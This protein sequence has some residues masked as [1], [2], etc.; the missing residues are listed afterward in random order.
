MKITE[1]A[2]LLPLN[3]FHIDVKAKVLAE[4]DTEEELIALLHRYEGERL[5][6]IGEGSN[7]LF[8]QDFDGVV[9][10]SRMRRASALK[11]NKDEVW[12]EAQSGLLLDNLISQLADM[13]LR[14]M[15]N[16]SYIPGTVGASAV[17]NVGAY[18]VE[19][20][21]VIVQVSTIDVK[22]RAKYT[23]SNLD[24]QFAY[25][26][27][28]FKHE[29]K[30]RYIITS[31]VYRLYKE[32]HLRL[33]YGGLGKV[34]EGKDIEELTPL[35][36]RE[37]VI[38][39]RREKLPEVLEFGSAGSFF[40]NPVV[41]LEQ[42]KYLAQEYAEIPHYEVSDGVKIPAGWLI[43]QAGLKGMQVGGARVWEK[44]ALVIVNVGGATSEDVQQLAERIVAEVKARFAIT[45]SPEVIIL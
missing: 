30:D 19:A 38:A 1:Q 44:Q 6:P 36:V 25:R 32:G 43:D 26:D 37:K 16:L 39:I 5:L 7:L 24:C 33:D 4:Y 21:D 10:H 8:T 12:I 11:E 34:F 15:E 9:L 42:Y 22:T 41:P 35:D 27:S 2:S 17:Q 14:G 45:L 28:R 20:K 31:V 3:T 13:D 29:W 40:K 18:G 23:F